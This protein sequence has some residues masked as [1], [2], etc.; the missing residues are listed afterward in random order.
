MRTQWSK[1]MTHTDHTHA[2]SAILA[3]F[4]DMATEEIPARAFGSWMA[5]K[6][7]LKHRDE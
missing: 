2:R 1:L 3:K 5:W 6:A 7:Y 4:R